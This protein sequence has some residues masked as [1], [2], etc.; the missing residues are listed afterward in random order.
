MSVRRDSTGTAT[1]SL[2]PPIFC[3]PSPVIQDCFS[4]L[5]VLFR[6]TQLTHLSHD[7][8]SFDANTFKGH[9]LD[10]T[11]RQM[12]LLLAKDTAIHARLSQLGSLT[13]STRDGEEA[14]SDGAQHFLSRT[15]PP[16]VYRSSLPMHLVCCSLSI[17][18][19]NWTK[20]E[21]QQV[22][23]RCVIAVSACVNLQRLEI[24]VPGVGSYGLTAPTWNTEHDVP[25]S[26]LISLH[27]LY[28]WGVNVPFVSLVNFTRLP[29]IIRVSCS[30]RI[31]H[32]ERPTPHKSLVDC[33]LTELRLDEVADNVRERVDCLLL[34]CTNLKR[35]E[36]HDVSL[37]VLL[38]LPSLTEAD[39]G[40]ITR[41]GLGEDNMDGNNATLLPSLTIVRGSALY[42]KVPGLRFLVS[43][44][45][46]QLR[47]LQ[48]SSV[49]MS[50]LP[51]TVLLEEC[52]QHPL[53]S[54]ILS[55]NSD[56]LYNTCSDQI[57]EPDPSTWQ[58]YTRP[59][60]VCPPLPLLMALD[61][62]SMGVDTSENFMGIVDACPALQSLTLGRHC[63][64]L[65]PHLLRRLGRACRQL[66]ETVFQ[67]CY[68]LLKKEEGQARHE[69]IN[70]D[71]VSPIF[72]C[73][74]V[75]ELEFWSGSRCATLEQLSA[76]VSVFEGAPLAVL[77]LCKRDYVPRSRPPSSPNQP[78]SYSP[79]LPAAADELREF[80]PLT[81]LRV[82][83]LAWPWN[84]GVS[85]LIPVPESS[86]R[87][88][89]AA[90][91]T[92]EP[93][94]RWRMGKNQEW[95][96]WELWMRSQM[97]R[98]QKQRQS[99]TVPVSAF[100]V[101]RRDGTGELDGRGV[102]FD[103]LVVASSQSSGSSLGIT[104]RMTN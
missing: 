61:L 22:L 16:S 37:H 49:S 32:D 68:G 39:L 23:V 28:L 35:L 81:R 62:T 42:L 50:H 58:L 70:N 76:L 18:H 66:R 92:S 31:V 95:P 13:Y 90:M 98:L 103:S 5:S 86:P 12:W 33:K 83:D 46:N 4:Y 67:G 75:C 54:L 7:F 101:E 85:Y 8:P 3:L 89:A 14:N 15:V 41:L 11:P 17:G 71:G 53:C 20:A 63:S 56:R 104:R 94:W 69:P 93:M 29:S 64:Y 88:L 21:Q 65:T 19:L 48:L 91:S 51:L 25:F 84:D 99:A 74:E 24:S 100:A 9:H 82:F 77:L 52:R 30:K 27:S 10:A 38:G 26:Q 80:S 60:R 73:L 55:G 59:E 34:D 6:F 44:A 43:R 102:F 1:R 47:C 2:F 72:P 40:E 78:W 97:T 36:Y 45:T 79:G 96:G 57:T 87:N